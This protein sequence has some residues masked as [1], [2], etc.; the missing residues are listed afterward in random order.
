MS[1]KITASLMALSISFVSLPI[2]TAK[3]LEPVSILIATIGVGASAALAIKYKKHCDYLCN[4][5]VCSSDVLNFSKDIIDA[6]VSASDKNSPRPRSIAEFCLKTCDTIGSLTFHTT[7]TPKPLKN[8][9]ATIPDVS[10]IEQKEIVSVDRI[11]LHQR[12]GDTWSI[13]NCAQA[14]YANLRKKGEHIPQIRIDSEAFVYNQADLDHVRALEAN[15][16]IKGYLLWAAEQKTKLLTG[17][18]T[19]K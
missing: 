15:N 5:K 2:Y 14:Y 17:S 6:V 3:A 9:E 4:K 7:H 10:T 12:F 13:E 16:N 19:L 1:K 8:P 11:T 18:I